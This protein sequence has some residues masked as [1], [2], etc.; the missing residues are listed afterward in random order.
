[1]LTEGV[2]DQTVLRAP[3]VL[4]SVLTMAVTE[5]TAA[6]PVAKI[7]K[8]VRTVQRRVEPWPPLAVEQLRTRLSVG[9]AT[10]ISV[11]AYSGLAPGR[12]A[13]GHRV[14]LADERVLGQ[15]VCRDGARRIEPGRH[16]AS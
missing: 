7:K 9:Q 14:R 4:Q 5:L 11:L 10:V 15:P 12:G 1:M 3:A 6:N 16:P 2:V 8:P 13:V